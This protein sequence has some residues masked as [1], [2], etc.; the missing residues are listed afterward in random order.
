[1]ATRIYWLTWVFCQFSATWLTKSRVFQLRFTSGSLT[2]YLD[3]QYSEKLPSSSTIDD[4]EGMLAK[5]IPSGTP[6]VSYELCILPQCWYRILYRQ[7][8]VRTTCWRRRDCLQTLW[9][10]DLFI[11]K[12]GT[13]Q[14]QRQRCCNLCTG[15]WRWYC[16]WSLSC[17]ILPRSLFVLLHWPRSQTTWDTPGFRAY[18]RRMQLFILL[19]VEAGSYI[20]EDEDSWEFVVLWISVFLSFQSA[21]T[22]SAGTKRESVPGAIYQLIISSVILHYTGSTISPRKLDCA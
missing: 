22:S 2:Y 14:G 1:M 9:R 18:H 17:N 13:D 19:Y 4:V 7:I 5:F 11:Y 16:I 15:D 6:S 12:T 21:L 3:V 10:A 8:W 20:V